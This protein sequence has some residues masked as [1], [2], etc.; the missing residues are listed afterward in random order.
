MRNKKVW[1]INYELGTIYQ[2]KAK[3]AKSECVVQVNGFPIT[4]NYICMQSDKCKGGVHEGQLLS[5][6]LGHIRLDEKVALSTLLYKLTKE[7][8]NILSRMQRALSH[9]A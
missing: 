3:P 1:Y 9:I 6:E 4:I 7:Q 8:E 2:I 5:F